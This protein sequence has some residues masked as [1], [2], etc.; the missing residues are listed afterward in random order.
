MSTTKKNDNK[1]KSI[2]QSFESILVD[3]CNCCISEISI[4]HRTG[5]PRIIFKNGNIYD[6]GF[7]RLITAMNDD[8]K[9]FCDELLIKFCSFSKKQVDRLIANIPYRINSKRFKDS[10]FGFAEIL[11]C[12]A[13]DKHMKTIQLV[14]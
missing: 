4:I 7:E 1:N 12:Y 10:K 6:V 14:Q 13:K 8:R 11:L 5:R 9:V 3:N 2:I